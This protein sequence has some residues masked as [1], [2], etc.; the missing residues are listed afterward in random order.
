VNPEDI[1]EIFI[2]HF[3]E[4]AI[5]YDPRIVHCRVD[6]SKCIDALCNQ[7]FATCAGAHIIAIG[8]RPAA[9]RLDFL[10]DPFGLSQIDVIHDD[11]GT[12]R[13]KHHRMTSADAST[14]TRHHYAFSVD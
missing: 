13:R 7:C 11:V 5:P 2:R 10:D 9:G 12:L 4:R 1:V 8:Y 14:G 6:S 3:Q